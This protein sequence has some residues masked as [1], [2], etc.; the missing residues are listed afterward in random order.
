MDKQTETPSEDLKVIVIKLPVDLQ[1]RLLAFPFLHALRSYYPDVDVHFITPK[2]EVEVLNLLRFKAFYHEFD[3]DEFT[4]VL[5]AHRF[6]AT[7]K[8]L[9]VDVFFSLT[10]SFVDGCLGIALRAKKRVGFS[11]GWKTMLFNEKT[12]RP[13][14]HHLCEDYFALYKLHTGEDVSTKLKVMSRDLEPNIPA[15]DRE[16]YVAVNLSPLW[17][18]KQI[19]PLWTEFISCFQNQRFIFFATDD[20]GK[21]IHLLGDFLA[22]LPGKNVYESFAHTSYIELAKMLAYAKGIVTFNGP[23]ASLASYV[24][25]RSLVIYDVEDPQRTGPFYFRSDVLIMGDGKDRKNLNIGDVFVKAVEFFRL[26][27]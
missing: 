4:T 14:N 24:G 19:E 18:P 9:N 25:S 7:A 15:W 20:Q 6:C 23:V 17:D 11:D 16:P 27:L 8:I 26:E 5:D 10:N 12:T 2:K 13:V 22:T 21:I 1:E 3:E